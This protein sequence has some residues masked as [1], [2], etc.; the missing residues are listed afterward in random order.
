M[1]RIRKEYLFVKNGT[2]YYN[3]I[4]K[5]KGFDLTAEPPRIK[6]C[7]VAPG[8]IRYLFSKVIKSIVY[9]LL[10][11]ITV[12]VMFHNRNRRFCVR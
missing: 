5:N 6:L 8:F 12:H 9:L 7:C 3:G 10:Y 2:Q 11:E 4:L 1:K